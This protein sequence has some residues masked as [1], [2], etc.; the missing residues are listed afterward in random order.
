[1]KQI[2]AGAAGGLQQN[3]TKSNNSKLSH[4]TNTT[5]QTTNINNQQHIINK[6]AGV[7]L[8]AISMLYY[9]ILYNVGLL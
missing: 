9:V 7:G 1:M 8:L 6:G 2:H 3:A 4:K 5:K